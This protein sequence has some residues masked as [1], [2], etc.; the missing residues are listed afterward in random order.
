VTASLANSQ[1][2]VLEN[3]AD[4]ADLA[5]CALVAASW[6]ATVRNGAWPNARRMRIRSQGD[7][8]AAA[9]AWAAQR[10]TNIT[11]VLLSVQQLGSASRARCSAQHLRT[12]HARCLRALLPPR[13]YLV[14]TVAER[15]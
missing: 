14:W 13:S 6:H 5:R 8:A 11:E 1:A 12:R 7:G 3:L 9:V 2:L 15:V 4:V 10:C